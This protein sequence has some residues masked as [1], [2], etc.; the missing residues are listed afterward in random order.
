MVLNKRKAP[1]ANLKRRK[2]GLGLP[3]HIKMLRTL[4]NIDYQPILVSSRAL[5]IGQ[6]Y[7]PAYWSLRGYGLYEPIISSKKVF[8]FSLIHFFLSSRDMP[9]HFFST[10]RSTAVEPMSLLAITTL[11]RIGHPLGRI[12]RRGRAIYKQ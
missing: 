8:P 2:W 1:A 12:G 10:S 4:S 6:L 5:R 7:C 11:G 3:I 9:T